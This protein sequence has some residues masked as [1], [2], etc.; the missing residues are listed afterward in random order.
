MSVKY[1]VFV[2]KSLPKRKL[3]IQSTLQVNFTKYLDKKL[4]QFYTTFPDN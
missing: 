2:S 3:Q 1:S 4:Y